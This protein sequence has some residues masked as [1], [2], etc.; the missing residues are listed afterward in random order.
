MKITKFLILLI[1]TL[2]CI[3]SVNAQSHNP[4]PNSNCK[5]NKYNKF[6][7]EKI[8]CPACDAITKKENEAKAAE[9]KRRAEAIVAKAK[10][11]K[12]ALDK[13]YR[14]KLALDAKNREAAGKVIVTDKPKSTNTTE[15]SDNKFK[16]K[17]KVIPIMVKVEGGTF[18]MGRNINEMD[19]SNSGDG[20]PTHSVT[21]NS[22][23][24]G[25]YEVTVAEYKAFCT[26]TGLSMPEAPREGWN[27]NH[28]IVNVTFDD[29]NAYCNWLSKT[30]GKNF[31][32]PTEAEWEYAAIGGRKSLGYF[33]AGSNDLD[34]VGWV[35]GNGGVQTQTC[36]RKKANELGL[37]DMSGNVSE[38][39][40]DWYAVY[41]ESPANNP[42]GP[43]SGECRVC[44]GGSWG[45]NA[46]GCMVRSR[47]VCMR[48]D[49]SGIDIGFRLVSPE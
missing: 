27:D 19:G 11:E 25:K 15:A 49:Q 37:Y 3:T 6:N 10:A 32:L 42:K 34:E 12:D 39:C 46:F 29:A 26:A 33:L 13:A 43:S 16:I 48:P 14:D 24:I 28:P 40:S 2:L 9:D 31:R 44:R 20:K 22:F 1:F 35:I 47:G 5:L 23:S 45:N 8:S 4:G 36:G 7:I 17:D 21:V 38:Q 30:T 41:N 18:T